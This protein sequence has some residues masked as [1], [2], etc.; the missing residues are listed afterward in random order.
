VDPSQLTLL[1]TE[2]DLAEAAQRMIA[3]SPLLAPAAVFAGGVVTAANP[4]VLATVPLLMAY[5]GARDDVRSFGR[6][7]SLSLAFVVGLSMVFAL[8]G[9]AAALAGAML[10]DFGPVWDYVVLVVCLLMG[11][12][13]LGWVEVPLPSVSVSPRVRGMPGAVLLGGLF[14]VV[15]TPCAT[16]ILVVVL[17]YI[18]GSGSSP[19]YGALLLA[20]YA[21]GHSVLI[22]TAGASAGLARTLLRSERFTRT[23]RVLRAVAGVLVAAVGVFYFLYA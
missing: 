11:A 20:A 21:L 17:A 18:A 2:A 22:L 5:V 14:G 4:C 6:G 3:E 15:S 7:V 23:G 19:A 1:A 12:H 16:P 13:L 8:L 9:V 10:G